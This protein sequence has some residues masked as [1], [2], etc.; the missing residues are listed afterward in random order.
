MSLALRILPRA[1]RD[2]QA[3]FEYISPRSEDGAIRWWRAFDEAAHAVPE[4]P[5]RY[6]FAPENS[7]SEFDVRQF[8]FKTP[9]GRRYRGVFVVVGS[10][11]RVLRVRGPGQAKLTTDEMPIE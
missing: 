11:V 3:I 7:L 10:Q 1:E 9:Q 2:V 4:N 8:F 5:E 6:G